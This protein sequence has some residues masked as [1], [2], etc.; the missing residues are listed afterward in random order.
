MRSS[1]AASVTE[2]SLLAVEQSVDEHE[3]RQRHAAERV[4]R[5][6]VRDAV[7]VFEA[8]QRV[9]YASA[10][11]EPPLF[12]VPIAST[13]IDH[14]AA[15]ADLEPVTAKYRDA[16]ARSVGASMN[17]VVGVTFDRRNQL[18]DGVIAGQSGM[19]IK[20]AP[21]EVVEHMMAS[22]Q[23][24]HDTGASIPKAARGMRQ[25]GYTGSKSMAE[26]IARTELIR[27]TNAASLAMAKGGTTMNRKVWMAKLD[28]RT[29]HAHALANGQEVGIDQAFIVGG[30]A[31]H[32]PGD[33]AGSAAN[34]VHCRCTLG[35][36][37]TTAGGMSMATTARAALAA[38]EAPDEAPEADDVAAGGAKW[39]GVIAQEGVDTGDGRRIE[40]GALTWR[41]LPLTLM[42]QK[43]T[44]EFGGHTDAAVCGRID[45]IT[46]SGKDIIA[47]G[48]FD[49][50]EWG[51]DIE[52][53]VR[54]GMLKGVSVD[55]AVNEAEVE[56]DPDIE[57]PMEAYFMGTLVVKDG[58]ILGATVVPFPAFEN[59]SIA[60][61][62]GAAMT[63]RNA[64]RGDDGKMI[65]SFFMPF[66][67]EVGVPVDDAPA[68][69]PADDASSD[70]SSVDAAMSAVEDATSALDDALAK[71]RSAIDAEATSEGD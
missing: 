70:A 52:R 17:G 20:T 8:A 2:A 58:T 12:T 14:D 25:A 45:A 62:A 10:A 46:R 42:G 15:N 54:D 51:A 23:R 30:E 22:L 68:D 5:G 55:L 71:L 48:A 18:I 16:A 43:T 63:L 44:P 1:V 36:D 69:E 33:P 32:Y 66:A 59:A 35:Y 56:E 41:A 64:R 3:P 40:A 53:M 47:S 34:V 7:R 29:R 50:G 11:E 31:M 9:V 49:T 28:S 67:P 19:M 65:V 13:L 38:T 24:S 39:S 26:R 27:V 4:L 60:I 61:V 57:D 37:E 21:S 6:Y